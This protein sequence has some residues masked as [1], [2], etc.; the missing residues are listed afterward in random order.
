MGIYFL[1]YY[2]L[3][4]PVWDLVSVWRNWGS[5]CFRYGHWRIFFCLL[6]AKQLLICLQATVS[7]LSWTLKRLQELLSQCPSKVLNLASC[8][9]LGTTKTQEHGQVCCARRGVQGHHQNNLR[10][11][12]CYQKSI[13]SAT[14][15]VECP[16]LLLPMMVIAGVLFEHRNMTFVHVNDVRQRS[17]TGVYVFLPWQNNRLDSS[18]TRLFSFTL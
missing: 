1:F 6:L 15:P 3:L 11:V 9:V 12:K 8:V 2:C 13:G 16:H 5:S 10:N 14:R 17:I 7:S 4:L 18:H